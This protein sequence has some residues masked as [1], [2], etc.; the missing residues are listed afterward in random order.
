MP[1]LH[2]ILAV[3]GQLE[4]QAKKVR[5][6]LVATFTSKRH[7]FEEKRVLFTPLEENAKVVIETQSD[8]QSNVQ[9]ELKWIQPF[10]VKSFDASYQVAEANTAAR[11]DV[12]LDDDAK[13]VILEQVPATALLELEKRIT[14]L[15]TLVNAIP[16]LDPAKGFVPDAQR[17]GLYKAREIN[18]NRTRKEKTVLVKIHPTKEHPGQAELIDKDIAVGTIQEQEWSGLIT[19]SEK[20]EIIARVEQIGRAV[21]RARSRA[22]D[23]EVN[24]DKHIGGKILKYVFQS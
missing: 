13:T 3:E 8:I 23:V 9:K 2:E 10:I 22:N 21:R 12:V 15:Q 19:P 20:A 5:D 17:T 4:S 1:K 11:A 6:D 14:E 7:L 18:K 16:T 24:T